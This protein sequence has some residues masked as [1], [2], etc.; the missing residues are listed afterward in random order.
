MCGRCY[1][2]DIK[3]DNQTNALER[4][5]RSNRME[6]FYEEDNCIDLNLFHYHVS[7]SLCQDNQVYDYQSK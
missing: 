6:V 5:V 4:D 1:N 7:N 2:Q 3:F